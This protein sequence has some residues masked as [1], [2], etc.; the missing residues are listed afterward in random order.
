MTADPT[1]SWHALPSCCPDKPSAQPITAV[2]AGTRSTEDISLHGH[3]VSDKLTSQ[4]IPLK[5]Y[6]RDDDYCYQRS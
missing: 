1:G 4:L 2:C 5:P 6:L 3:D